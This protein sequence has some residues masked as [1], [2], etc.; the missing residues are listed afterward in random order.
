MLV[1][2]GDA[3]TDEPAEARDL[4]TSSYFVLKR[5]YA[6]AAV[7]WAR[8]ADR[9][10]NAWAVLSAEHGILPA[11]MEIE[12]YNTT[13]NDLRDVP[14]DGEPRFELPSGD[15]VTT[16]LDRWAR[17]VHSGLADWLRR[18]F[19]ADQPESP[20]RELVVLAGSDYVD[21]LRERGI[22]EGRPTALETGQETHT[23][24]PPKASVRFPFQERDFD[25]M[26]EQMDWLSERAEELE[27]IATPARTREL[28]VFDAGYD[29]DQARWQLDRSSVDVE[30]TEQAG[31]D[32][33]EEVSDQYIATEQQQLCSS[34][35]SEN[36]K[37]Q[38]ERR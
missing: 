13:I 31:L 38:N 2:C 4:Y 27:A 9:R 5:R 28:S 23:A 3:K 26:F 36:R 7:Q 35:D 32:A 12:P 34:R 17:R 1:G 19:H 37:N 15:P 8:T 6:E 25:G 16:K 24:L 29:R 14:I 30:A 20:C 18:P 10:A 33:F 22:F 11:R 21:A